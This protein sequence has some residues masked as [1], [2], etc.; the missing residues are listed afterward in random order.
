MQMAKFNIRFK[1][2]RVNL[3][4]NRA[5]NRKWLAASAAFMVAWMVLGGNKGV[6]AAVQ[7]W[8]QARSLRAE[9]IQLEETNAQ[10]AEDR[11]IM[12][13]DPRLYE[14]VA[15]ETLMLARPGELIYRSDL[16]D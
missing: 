4:S 11:R 15:R 8:N 7:S 13:S 6:I 5:A 10:L 9:I 2:F 3:A 14:K 1:K 16:S 12:R